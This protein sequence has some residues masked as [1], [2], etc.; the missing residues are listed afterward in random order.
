MSKLP[1]D[2]PDDEVVQ[3]DPSMGE[4]VML[5]GIIGFV[6]GLNGSGNG[7]ILI[8]GFSALAIVGG[9]I[10]NRMQKGRFR[11]SIRTMLIA[12][13][14]VVILTPGTRWWILSNTMYHLNATISI[15]IE[16]KDKVLNQRIRFFDNIA[17]IGGRLVYVRPTL[18]GSSFRAE[19]S[20]TVNYFEVEQTTFELRQQLI[21]AV[22]QIPDLQ[23][24]RYTIETVRTSVLTSS[25]PTRET[26]EE[27]SVE[28]LLVSGE[29][30]Q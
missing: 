10:L 26:I 16:D 23:F 1:S 29:N 3:T 25:W 6:I 5:L 4:W 12:V 28:E 27:G 15:R 8:C 19:Y 22:E 21:E 30:R 14:V 13:A 20:S 11:F 17:E 2:S 24:D 18:T 7:P 9:I